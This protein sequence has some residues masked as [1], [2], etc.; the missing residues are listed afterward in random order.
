MV[1]SFLSAPLLDALGTRLASASI[2]STLSVPLGSS[3]FTWEVLRG[4]TDG[5]VR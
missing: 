4:R 2:Y 1:C 5:S 3:Y